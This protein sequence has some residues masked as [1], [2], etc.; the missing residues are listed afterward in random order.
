MLAG[1][2]VAG[3]MV[4]GVTVAGSGLTPFSFTTGVYRNR[5]SYTLRP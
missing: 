4:A 3:A 5:V 1:V 2:T